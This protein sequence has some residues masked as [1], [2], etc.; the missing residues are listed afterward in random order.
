MMMWQKSSRCKADS[1]MCVE[2]DGLDSTEIMVRNSKDIVSSGQRFLS[3]SRDEWQAFI[4][5]V[6]RGEFDLR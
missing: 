3:F 6:K 5:G 1:P 4:D 2:V